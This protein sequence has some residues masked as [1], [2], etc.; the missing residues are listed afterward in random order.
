[1]NILIVDDLPELS[2]TLLTA[3]RKRGHQGKAVENGIQ[4]LE[5]VKEKD[6]DLLLLDIFLPDCLGHELIPRIKAIAPDI[7]IITMTGHNTRELELEVRKAGIIFYLIKPFELKDLFGIMDH[8]SRKGTT[9]TF[10]GEIAR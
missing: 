10:P 8:L 2:R 4:A 1:M 6:F 3:I 7:N 5:A 9:S